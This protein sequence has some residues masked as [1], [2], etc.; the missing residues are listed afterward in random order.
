M[1]NVDTDNVFLTYSKIEIVQKQ[2]LIVSGT[3]NACGSVVKAFEP[4][5]ERCSF[6]SSKYSAVKIMCIDCNDLASVGLIYIIRI[7]YVAYGLFD[8][9]LVK[10]LLVIL[11]A[12]QGSRPRKVV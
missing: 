1:N 12:L 6:L 8:T 10:M 7:L 9:H 5:F 4:D 3:V 11:R 2:T